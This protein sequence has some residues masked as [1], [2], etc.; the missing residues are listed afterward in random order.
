MIVRCLGELAQ[1][2]RIKYPAVESFRSGRFISVTGGMKPIL[3]FT[4][5]QIWTPDI[6]WLRRVSKTAEPSLPDE[7]RVNRLGALR[8]SNLP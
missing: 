8:S 7:D 5:G 1:L 2:G 6:A 4:T 3:N